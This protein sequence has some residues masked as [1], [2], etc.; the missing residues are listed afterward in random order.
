MAHA[1]VTFTQRTSIP[2]EEPPIALRLNPSVIQATDA[3]V[4]QLRLEI[5]NAFGSQAVRILLSAYDAEGAVRFTFTPQVADIA[6]GR[7][8]SVLIGLEAPMPE[9]GGEALRQFT[10]V[11]RYGTR[12]AEASGTFRQRTSPPS[13]NAIKLRVEP[14]IVRVRDT[15]HGRARVV[16]DNRLGTRPARMWLAG[17]DHEGT[18]SI[19]FSAPYVDVYPGQQASADV[20][21]RLRRR[22]AGTE[23][24]RG[25]TISG[26]EASTKSW[27]KARSP[28][29][30]QIAGRCGARRSLLSAP[31]SWPSGT[32]AVDTEPHTFR[33]RLERR[34]HCGPVPRKGTDTRPQSR[35]A[36][37][38]RGGHHHSCG[39]RSL[40]P[41]RTQGTD[42]PAGRSARLVA[43][44]RVSHS[45]RREERQQ[46]TR[47]WRSHDHR[48]LRE[49]LHRRPTR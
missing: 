1:V 23:R 10:L 38:R 2:R 36:R 12:T 33:H 43:D 30:R 13:L 14:P 48:W 47:D 39:A 41:P 44:A 15:D 46:R 40:G 28:R 4:G 37:L 7:T 25:F 16:A 21:I 6:A 29:H 34:A 17:R 11:A 5:D 22:P 3:R 20:A 19:T 35:Q 24:T 45:R 49:R 31:C 18:A 27:Q 42:D 32:S 9:P 26:S 8:A